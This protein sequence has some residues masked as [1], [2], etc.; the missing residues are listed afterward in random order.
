MPPYAAYT[1]NRD[2]PHATRLSANGLSLPSAVT[3]ADDQIDFICG[4][5][6]RCLASRLLVLRAGS[7]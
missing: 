5:I 4:V 2:F 1:G 7:A 3:L 6:E